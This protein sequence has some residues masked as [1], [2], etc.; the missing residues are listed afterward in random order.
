MH[1]GRLSC[2]QDTKGCL[3]DQRKEERKIQMKNEPQT[4]VVVGIVDK[5]VTTKEFVLFFQNRVNEVFI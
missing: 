3:D 4:Q 1:F 2:H 5:K